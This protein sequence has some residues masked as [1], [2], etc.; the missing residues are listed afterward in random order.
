MKNKM[1]Y[2]TIG[3]TFLCV[4]GIGYFMQNG[5]SAFVDPLAGSQTVA[6]SEFK[7]LSESLL[8]ETRQA[9][10]TDPETFAQDMY[11]TAA[12]FP[13]ASTSVFDTPEANVEVVALDEEQ[14][15]LADENAS[16]VTETVC[17]I[18]AR[19]S[20]EAGA[21]VR[22]DVE[23]PCLP[24]E[25]V[26]VHHNGM[27][28]TATTDD[29]GEMIQMVPA[30][31]ETAIFIVEFENGEGAVATAD[32]SSLIFYE[33]V[34]LQWS[35]DTGL[36]L[37]AREFGAS[38]GADGHVWS[39]AARDVSAAAL[40]QGG[41]LMPL[42]DTGMA[43]P[44]LAEVYTFPSGTASRQGGI[45]LTVEAEVAAS[46]CGREIEG[47]AIEIV[48]AGQVRTRYLTVDMPDCGSIG[49][50]LVLNNLVDDLKI[51]TN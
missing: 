31:S 22:L 5:Q 25:R 50:F 49:D 44:R 9:L 4:L 30:L 51:A 42:G 1:R 8:P 11:I 16:D 15:A 41:F 45:A 38:Y 10:P 12:P 34:V 20:A 26:I 48:D 39:G 17:E 43:S 13:P 27:M 35:G 36:Q 40:G 3:G 46:N 32:V 23:A 19:A 33:R 21:I 6:R 37:H 47:Q 18:T 24:N 7:P 2:V 28:F 29:A 14:H